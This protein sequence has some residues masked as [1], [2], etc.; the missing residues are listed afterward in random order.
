[1]TRSTWNWLALPMVLA[2]L[3][4]FVPAILS[5]VLTSFHPATGIGQVG[6]EW[7][8]E[9]YAR[10][11]GD[12]TFLLGLGR[13]VQL[14]VITVI[15]TLILGVPL[16]YYI[17]R[18]PSRF[19][20]GVF[21]LL[22]VSS[23]TSI[24]IRGLGWITLLGN[25]GP[26]NQA[27][28]GIGV[29][30]DPIQLQGNMLGLSIA[31][32]HYMLPFMVL[33]LLPVVQAIPGNLEEA[34]AGLGAGFLRTARSVIVPIATPGLV[35][36]SLLVF[37]MTISAFVIPRMVGGST[38]RLTSLLIDQQMLTTYNYA[39]GSTLATILLALVA[40]VIVLANLS[41]R[42]RAVA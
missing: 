22:Y 38:L 11:L 10:V 26:I 25:N 7:T 31:M 19:A 33:T 5:F 35:A 8:L 12:E 41:L 21:T 3:A 28:L 39:L 13:S 18:H 29:I 37:A 34:S 24:V 27:L 6:P 17:A 1:M 4:I 16:T 32:I 36:G 40:G 9:N 2:F 30:G 42:R 15:G 14:G 20:I 23:L